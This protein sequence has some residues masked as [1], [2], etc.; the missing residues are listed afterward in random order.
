MAKPEA[1][2]LL[3][4]DAE[5]LAI[6]SAALQDALV[7][8]GDIAFDGPSRRLTVACNRYRWEGDARKERVRSGLQLGGVMSVQSRNL[9]RDAK[10]AVIELLAVTFEPGEA[11]GGAVVFTFAGGGDLRAE[12]ECL[13]LVLADVSPPWTARRAPAHDS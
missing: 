13:D 1:L 4:E 3:A 9:R 8:I 6:I 12:V 10:A 2:R 7:R 11:P 5:D